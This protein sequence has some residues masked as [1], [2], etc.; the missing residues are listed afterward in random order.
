[1]RRSAS[2]VFVSSVPNGDLHLPQVKATDDV[3]AVGPVDIVFFTVKLYDTASAVPMLQAL[4]GPGTIV[5]PFQNG[6]ETVDV[7]TR[8]LGRPHVAGGT[9]YIV[10][11]IID[12]GI[13]RHTAL[14]KLVFGSI[15]AEQRPR[16]ERLLEQCPAARHRCDP[17]R[18]HLG[19]Y[20]G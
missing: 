6:V 19:R 20:L 9:T 10:A 16:L 18:Q 17:Q 13:I 14:G 1:M 2:V 5:V 12:P 4:V 7:L 11:A 15:E 8:A 3:T